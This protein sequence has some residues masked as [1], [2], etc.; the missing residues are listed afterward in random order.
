M[1][2]ARIRDGIYAVGAQIPTLRESADE[3]QVDKN[4]VARAYKALERK[5]YLELIRGRGAFVVRDEPLVGRLDGRWLQRLE[6]LLADAQRHSLGR[7]E[8]MREISQVVDRV[9]Q[10]P[11]HP[12]AFVECNPTDV[13]VLGRKLSDVIERPLRGILLEDLLKRPTEI[14]SQFELL[15][16]TF[17]HLSEAQQAL[18]SAGAQKVIGV[19]T[20][21]SHETL[22]KIARLQVPMIGFVYELPRAVDEVIHTIRSYHPNATIVPVPVRE[23][24]R[25]Q[26]LCAKADAIIVTQ[27]CYE[28]LMAMQ[29]SV[30]V[31]VVAMTIDPQ[32]LDFLRERIADL[33]KVPA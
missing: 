31:I 14:A 2:E 20:M 9:Y 23:I 10:V 4:T 29:P 12:L 21:P 13:Q 5:G 22:L 7:D 32:S 27:M 26:A 28:R 11:G 33:E 1:L 8:V 19:H 6:H 24:S 25:L 3:L 30:P 15:V 16:T 17:Y 18:G